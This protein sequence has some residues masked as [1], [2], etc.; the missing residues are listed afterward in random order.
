MQSI[1]TLPTTLAP[2]KALAIETSIPAT[3]RLVPLSVTCPSHSGLLGEVWLSKV[4]DAKAC[5]AGWQ[6]P[7][8]GAGLCSR[9]KSSKNF[10]VGRVVLVMVQT[11][12]ET[13]RFNSIGQ[14]TVAYDRP[15]LSKSLAIG[16]KQRCWPINS[17]PYNIMYG[18]FMSIIHHQHSSTHSI[19]QSTHFHIPCVVHSPFTHWTTRPAEPC[20]T[21]SR[22][23]PMGASQH[24]CLKSTPLSPHLDSKKL[25]Q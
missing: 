6:R 13:T 22:S 21:M 12:I 24:R 2:P 14:P 20:A 7:A 8:W 5:H 25:A 10:R 17:F 16:F 9:A 19:G 4:Q 18:Q 3:T 23:G 1:A 11:V 15:N